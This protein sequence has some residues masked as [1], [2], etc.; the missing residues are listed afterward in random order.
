M[1]RAGKEAEIV[2]FSNIS[3]I[4]LHKEHL[5][6]RWAAVRSLYFVPFVSILLDITAGTEHG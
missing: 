6:R 5:N 4:I 1:G 2:L 3:G